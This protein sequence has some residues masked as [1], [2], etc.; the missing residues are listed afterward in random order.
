MTKQERAATTRRA[1]IR[2]AAAAFDQHG[3]AQATL[4][5]ISSHAGVST[6]ALHFH[7]AN[8]AALAAAVEAMTAEALHAVVREA[9]RSRKPALQVLTDTSHGVLR[10]LRGDIVFRAGF[11]LNSDFA[12]TSDLDVRRAWH[13]CVTRLVD[14]AVRQGELD[15]GVVARDVAAAV[16]AATTGFGLLGRDSP[17]WLSQRTLAGFWEL[18]LPRIAGPNLIGLLTPEGEESVLRS[19]ALDQAPEGGGPPL[20]A[21]HLDG[22]GAR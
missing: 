12:W 4:N 1:L 13:A 6:G 17:E 20:H 10:L 21:H 18:L 7:F 14:E 9:H 16:M 5:G 2:S 11:R 22:G 19:G 15:R 3:Y 8:K